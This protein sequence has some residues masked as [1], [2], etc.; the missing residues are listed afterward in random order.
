MSKNATD[1]VGQK[2]PDFQVSAAVPGEGETKIET[3]SN[4]DFAGAPLILFFYP[5]DATSGCTVE[6]DGFRDAHDDFKNL[7]VQVVGASRDGATSHRRFIENRALPFPLLCDRE[8]VLAEKLG[9][10]VAKTM[11][12]KPVTGSRRTTFALDANGVVTRVWENVAPENHAQEVL[13]WCRENL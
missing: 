8:R 7:G 2:F 13:R 9:L 10:L 1:F 4:S 11:Y 12:G 5:K 6:A 3:R